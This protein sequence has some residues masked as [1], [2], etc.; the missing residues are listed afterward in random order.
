MLG[1][2]MVFFAIWWAWMNFTW[3]ASAYDT[4][5]VL[6][7]VATLVQIAGVLVLAAGVPA[8]VRARR[9]PVV[10]VGYVIMRLALVAQWL[11]A[12]AVR[13]TAP[14]DRRRCGTRPASPLCQV[15]WL[16]AAGP[17][18]SRRRGLGLPAAGRSPSCASRLCAETAL[19]RPPGTR[20]TSPSGTACSPSSCWAS[21]SP[22]PRSP[23]RRRV[24]E[25]DALGE[26]L[27]LA[28]GGLL[29]V[30]AALVD[31]LRGA[32]PRPPAVQPP[33]RFLW[34]YGHYLIFASA[35]AIGAGLEVAVEQAVG[36]AH[37][38]TLAAS[39]AVTLPTALY[40]LMVWLLHARHFKVGTASNSSCPRPRCW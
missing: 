4:D 10:G 30:F 31:L 23:C 3:F 18:A 28:V 6:Y 36:K 20:T 19:R 22:R 7:R 32:D 16:R 39:A 5:D 29:I 11:R 40:F 21:R 26:L 13:P 25:H 17:A 12:A 2:L 9:L 27:P 38:S 8:G 33:G 14:S 35:A 1:Y 34:G 15:G 24:D 37:I